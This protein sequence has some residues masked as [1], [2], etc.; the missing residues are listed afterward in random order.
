MWRTLIVTSGE[1]MTV[2]DGWLYVYSPEQEARVPIGDL[3]SVVVD[4]RRTLLS[5]GV[6]TQLA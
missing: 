3:Y 4:N 5:M 6:L 1:K 2:R